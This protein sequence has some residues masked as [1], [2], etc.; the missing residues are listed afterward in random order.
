MKTGI[1]GGSF[2]PPHNSHIQLCEFV[3]EELDLDKIIL[4]PTG[5]HPFKRK[6]GISKYDR[7]EMCRLAVEG[8]EDYEVSD[9]EIKKDT[10]SYT[11]D[12]IS[13]MK[14]DGNN[15]E[16]YFISGSDILF[17][18]TWWKNLRGLSELV[19]FVTVMRDG[20]DNSQILIEAE[21]INRAFGTK[22]I[23]LESASPIGLSST[24][25][26]ADI[27]SAR[28]SLHP[29]VYDYIMTKGLYQKDR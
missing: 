7:L 5:E 8:K 23:L 29:K 17:E 11:Y 18:L 27:T 3:K 24:E 16:Y 4:I 6:V 25:I 28:D 10:P 20:V 21:K 22:I 15:D 13:E 2:N 26:R 19:S 12:T 1:L 9:I 14:S